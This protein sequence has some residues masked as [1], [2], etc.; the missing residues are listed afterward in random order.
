MELEFRETRL[1]ELWRRT[2]ADT[3]LPSEVLRMRGWEC[4]HDARVVGHCLADVGTGEIL[5]LSV[6]HSHRRQG[7][8]RRLLALLI[9]RL[10]A[11]GVRR[12][13][14]A[15]SR[16]ASLPAYQFYRTLGWR[17]TGERLDCGDE[18]LELLGGAPAQQ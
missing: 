9:A 8:A 10:Q 7:I 5:G 11:E 4:L 6:D 18:I 1:P 12:I 3:P 17:P 2:H 13:W 15:A 14:L 16:D